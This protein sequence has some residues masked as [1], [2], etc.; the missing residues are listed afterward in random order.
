[1]KTL[2]LILFVLLCLSRCDSGV[3]PQPTVPTRPTATSEPQ[4]GTQTPVPVTTPP[5]PAADQ[6]NVT[7]TEPL[8]GTTVR[9]NPLLVRGLARTFENHVEIRIENASGHTLTETFTTATG[10]LGSFNPFQKEIFLVRDPGDEMTVTLIE[11]SAKDGSVRTS[12]SA[13]VRVDIPKKQVRLYFPNQKSDP[14]DCSD[15]EPVVR[16]LPVSLSAARLALEALVAGPTQAERVIGETGPFPEGTEIRSVNLR[17]GT[18]TVDFGERLS[19]VGGSCRALAIRASVEKTLLDVEGV[20]RVVITA[21]GDAKT[22][23]QP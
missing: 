21:M 19:N 18:L 15:V 20:N 4:D 6:K 11:R 14:N 7:L 5:T 2:S 9:Q 22:A 23:L 13:R 17:N 8:Y 12:D 10:E 16:N 3:D 1:M